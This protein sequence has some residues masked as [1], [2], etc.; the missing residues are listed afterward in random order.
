MGGGGGVTLDPGGS[1][2]PRSDADY[3]EVKTSLGCGPAQISIG[4]KL[5]DCGNA[6][7]TAEHKFSEGNLG[8]ASKREKNFTT[9]KLTDS[10]PS[11]SIGPASN[12][13]CSSVFCG[14]MDPRT[15]GPPPT[16]NSKGGPKSSKLSC[17]AQLTATAGWCGGTDF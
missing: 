4:A 7:L 12:P 11:M 17:K 13:G 2:A 15:G 5:D 14:A 6:L 16:K 3:V 10:D 9:G 1:T 8:Y